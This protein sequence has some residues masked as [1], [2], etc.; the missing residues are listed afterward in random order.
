[1]PASGA[2]RTV[3][4]LTARRVATVQHDGLIRYRFLFNRERLMA[5]PAALAEVLMAKSYDF[6]K[7]AAV[8]RW[9]VRPLGSGVLLAEGDAHRVQRRNLQPAFGF[10][11]VKGLYPVFWRKADAVVRAMADEC[12]RQGGEKA[13]DAILEVNGWASRCTIDIIGVA[14]IGVDFGAVNDVHNPLASTYA[15]V[16]EPSPQARLLMVLA[17]FLPAWLVNSLPLRR[18]EDMAVAAQRIRAKRRGLADADADADAGP[19]IVSVALASGLFAN[20]ALVNQLMTFLATGHDTAASALTWAAYLL[21]C[22]PD[23][24]H[25]PPAVSSADVDRLPY[26]HAVCSEVLRVFSPVP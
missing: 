19:D 10:R 11:H 8:R 7:P 18:N 23:V 4:P 26:L 15:R 13:G 12:R 17:M 25:L 24:Q 2:R 22:H 21:A 14:G 1:M 5:S 20:D 16:A 6:T 9:L 3:L